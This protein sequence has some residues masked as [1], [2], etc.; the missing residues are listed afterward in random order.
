MFEISDNPVHIETQQYKS[1]A[2]TY[3]TRGHLMFKRW[4][5]VLAALLL[6]LL[7]LPW[8]QNVRSKGYITTLSPDQRPQTIQSTIAGRIEKWYVREGQLI[9]KGDTIVFLSEIKTDYFD[10]ELLS[11]TQAQ[12]N[13]KESSVQSYGEKARA[14]EEQIAAT[15]TELKFKKNQLRNKFEQAKLKVVS[16][17]NELQAANVDLE[18]ET[19]QLVRT[20]ELY[21]QG[22]K[23]LTEVENKRLKRQQ[24]QAK[25]T[26]SD[27]KLQQA[28]QELDNIELQ[29]RGIE[30]EYVAKNAKTSS[31]KYSTLS[32]RYEAQANVSKLK[33][34]YSNYA[35]RAQF[36]YITAPRDCYVTKAKAV[37]VGETVKEGEDIVSIVPAKMNLAV[38]M[39]IEPIDLPLVK[40]GTTVR[41]VFDGWPAFVFSGWP[42]T[43]VG[44]YSGRVVAVDN[45]ADDKGKFRL[46]IAPDSSRAAWPTALRPGSGASGI[47]LLND[48]P[49]WYELWRQLNGFPPEYY[50]DAER[51]KVKKIKLK[52]K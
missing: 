14:L 37:G 25:A 42:G 5:L 20:E 49:I 18:T 39:Y 1:F 2:K 33:N 13:A 23:S 11:R 9:K 21:R 41:F 22:L 30:S 3:L 7:F 47:A 24:T 19:K 50:S 16:E 48:V 6:T 12:V 45:V 10:P 34:Q 36:Y 40:L 8:T 52:V 32:D 28:Q 46:L 4:L 35:A 15:N 17:R 29:L 26:I 43:S 31:E 44:T 51:E 27:N 38:E